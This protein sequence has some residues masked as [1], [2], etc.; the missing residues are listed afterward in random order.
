MMVN[1]KLLARCLFQAGVVGTLAAWTI[2]PARAAC[3]IELAVYQDRDGIAEI[4]FEP[5]T[6]SVVVTN[7]FRMEFAGAPP[8]KGMVL[9]TENPSRPNGLIIHDCPEGDLTGAEIE[10]CTVWQGPIYAVD[11]QGMAGLVPAEGQPAPKGLLLA[12]FGYKIVGAAAF[13]LLNLDR[14]P[15][16]GFRLAG[17]Q[18]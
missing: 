8:F 7:Q 11:D 18:E 1:T 15:W 2:S 16:D 12:D 10:A 9:W 6:E 4:S 14:L 17:C 3:P 5:V 13:D